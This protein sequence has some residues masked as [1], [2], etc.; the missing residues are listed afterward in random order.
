MHKENL[1]Q[2]FLNVKCHNDGYLYRKGG[3]GAT[4]ALWIKVSESDIDVL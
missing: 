1:V 3:K 2:L 4:V